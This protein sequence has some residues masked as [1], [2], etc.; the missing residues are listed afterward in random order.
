[1]RNQEAARYARWAAIAAGTIAFVVISIYAARAISAARRRSALSTNVSSAVQQQSHTFSYNG[2]EGNRT[3]YTIR[4]SQATQFKEGNQALLEDVWITIYGREGNRDD[5]IH[6]RECSYQQKTGTVRC[7]GEVSIDL[8]GA[9]PTSGGPIQPALQVKTSNLTFDGQTGEASTPAPVEFTLPQGRGRGVGVSYSTQ[10]AIVRVKSAVEFEV[11]PSERTGGLPVTLAAASVEIRRNDRA[12][13]LNGPVRVQE[14]DRELS[15]Q[16]ITVSLDEN[17]HA[18]HAVAEG[19]PSIKAA[20]GGGA[21]AISAA[22]FEGYLTPEGWVERIAANGDVTGS[23]K[24]AAGS[25]RFSCERVEFSL[26]PTHNVLRDMTASGNVA[27]ESQAGTGSQALE[28][29]ALRVKFAPGARPD[30]QRVES[31]ET[32]GP[33]TINSRSDDELNATPRL[34]VHRA[35]QRERP[36]DS[37]AGRASR[38]GTEPNQEFFPANQHGAIVEGELRARRR[39]E[40]GGRNRRRKI[41]TG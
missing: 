29:T 5:N 12:V 17:F 11:A 34:K 10:A 25:D 37:F 23:R 20:E 39:V 15:A 28:T 7:E 31:A 19:H 36:L 27:A 41:P 1:M 14:A 32:V 16:K 35:T 13:I 40:H 4:A 9:S 30:Q 24:T 3:I 18:R 8:R 26:A 6:T 22:V 2:I 21:L 33:A 38:R